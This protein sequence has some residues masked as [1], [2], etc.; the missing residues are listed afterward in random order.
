MAEAM[1]VHSEEIQEIH[2]GEPLKDQMPALVHSTSKQINNFL[3]WEKSVNVER[4]C[5]KLIDL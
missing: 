5:K 3:K 1:Q 2:F 4:N